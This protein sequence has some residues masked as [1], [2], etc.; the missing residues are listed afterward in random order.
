MPPT[1]AETVTHRPGIAKAVRGCAIAKT[2]YDVPFCGGGATRKTAIF[3]AILVDRSVRR[4]LF[5]MAFPMLAGTFAMNAYNLTD[6]Y[7]VSRLGTVPLAAMAFTFPVVMF[8]TFTAGG[9][10]TGVTT[11]VSHAI[12]RQD[13]DD[14]AKLVTHGI[15]LTVI[16]TILLAMIGYLTMDPIFRWLGADER[17][18]PLVRSFMSLWY[19][20][21]LTMSLPMMGNGILISAGDS[22]GASWFMMG[23]AVLNAV[24]NP[25]FIFGYLGLP[26]MGIRGSAMATVAAQAVSTLWL[27][28]LLRYRHHL[29]S[30]GAWKLR[31]YLASFSRILRFAVPCILSMMLMPISAS[32]ITAI[33]SGF[34]HHAVAACG[35]AGRLEMFAFVIPMA[36]G[37]SL[38]PFISQNFGAKRLDRVRQAKNLAAKFALLYGAVVAIAFSAGAP[39]L[40]SL[41]SDDPEVLRTLVLYLRIIPFGYGM[42][43]VHRY[44]GFVLTGLHQPASTTVLNTIRVVVLLL[45]LSWLGARYFG[46]RG[47]FF[48]RLSTD[49]TI[50]TVGLFWVS[51]AL[52]SMRRQAVHYTAPSETEP[53]AMEAVGR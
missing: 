45:P 9:I 10:G 51:R 3:M 25:L 47:L 8:L 5:Q 6:A 26:A 39:W 29:L 17:T 24:L 33:V 30:R 7:F 41:F 48:G 32:V 19:F 42:M 20:G 18:M 49:V 38:T 11:L 12:G 35:A 13:H 14:A 44:C 2:G 27:F 36:L 34:G 50:G 16:C 53:R 43:E 4:T 40:A 22:K 15:T 46:V 52:A 23:G 28:Y 37:M 31:D 21:A 1:P